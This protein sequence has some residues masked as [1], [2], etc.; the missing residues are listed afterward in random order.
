[1]DGQPL[2]TEVLGAEAMPAEDTDA[3]EAGSQ[4]GAATSVSAIEMSMR[5]ADQGILAVLA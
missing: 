3:S 4:R 5:V 1:M 2:E